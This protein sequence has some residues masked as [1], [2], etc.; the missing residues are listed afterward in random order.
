MTSESRWARLTVLLG[1]VLA[2]S[3]CPKVPERTAFMQQ[4]TNVKA[5]SAE[6]RERA[7][8]LGRHAAAVVE[9]GADSI[10]ALSD[11]PDVRANALR[12]K[13]QIIPEIREASLKADPL[14]GLLELIALFM[15]IDDYFTTGAG[16]AQ[17]GPLQG[18]AIDLARHL[19]ADADEVGLV[20]TGGNDSAV[21]RTMGL[22][23]QW[24]ADHPITNSQYVRETPLGAMESIAANV[25]GIGAVAA[26]LENEMRL[27]QERIAF[28]SDYT[29]R[30][31]AWRTTLGV[32]DAVGTETVDSLRALVIHS[33]A[34][35]GAFPDLVRSERGALVEAITAER[36][37][38][39]R[40][41]LEH[42]EAVL[43]ALSSERAAT[44]EGLGA[45][46]AI[47]L[48][49]LSAERAAT[50]AGMDS[51][52]QH[53]LTETRSLV[54]HTLFI[55]IPAI[56]GGIVLAGAAA[57]VVVRYARPPA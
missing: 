34:L 51:I 36:V 43:A 53:G 1:I 3:A 2:T 32:E 33:A 19:I 54:N 20:I 18:V 16:R 7:A 6:V 55:V 8:D 35:M 28:M 21:T 10:R 30:E 41:M 29:A 17:F 31:I 24:A 4:A 42:R 52:L 47:L 22:L 46:R 23:R 12:F 27:L 14:V 9:L 26:N 39:L 5:S 44:M 40:E 50:L 49:A 15:Q 11:D 45:E 57:F 25:G 56:A 37:A 48:A 38:V 13:T